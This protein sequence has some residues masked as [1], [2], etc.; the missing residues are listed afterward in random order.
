M[1]ASPGAALAFL[2]AG[3]ATLAVTW[4]RM[5][6][7]AGITYLASVIIVAV[8]AGLALDAAFTLE[9][10]RLP[11]AALRAHEHPA[12]WWHHAAAAVLLVLLVR[13]LLQ[14]PSPLVRKGS[15]KH[16][17]TKAQR[18]EEDIRDA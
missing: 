12:A 1:G 14:R 10:L 18:L 16:K 2:I 7:R 9:S 5:G 17:G 4:K 11:A 6:A 13:P 15:R 3:P 8:A